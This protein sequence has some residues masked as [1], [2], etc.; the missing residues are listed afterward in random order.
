MKTRIILLTLA[1]SVCCV[2]A[3]NVT[4][5]WKAQFDTQ[6]GLQK[7]T[8]TLQQDGT[9]VS[10]NASAE[11]NGAKRESELKEGKIEGD[12]VSF[13]EPLNIQGNDLRITYTGKV[14]DNEIKFTRQVGDFATTEAVAKR[15]SATAP[16]QPAPAAKTVRIKAGKSEPVKDAE[17]NVWLADQG[18]EGGQT[19]ERPDIQI[20]NTKSP[21]LY[22]A[23]RY[24][25]DSFSWPVP[26]GKYV[27]KLH[28]AET[29]DGITG[30]GE[31]V[32]SFN[33][34]G[35]EFK[36]FDVWVKAGGA[37]KAYVERVPVE[38][39]NG[40]IK[41]TFTPKVENPQICALEIIPQT[42]AETGAAAP[43]P[44]AKTIRIKAG[45][46][47]PV[48]DAEGNVW[49]AD[50]G[51]EG[52][53]TI[54]RPDIQVANTK[55]P[56]LYRAEHY[57]MDSFSWPVPNGKYLV[58]LHF[59]ETFEGITGPGERVFSF[60][61]QGKEFKDFDVWVKAGGFLKAYIETVPVEV[62]EG[63]IKVTFTPKVENPQICAIEI[64]PQ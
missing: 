19:I 60:N 51:F 42:G 44:A 5:V 26:N 14:A 62:T 31:R 54:E 59:A 12:T 15:E 16:A 64:I 52:G 41:V 55:N 33:V 10:G 61:V 24:S 25:M 3:A 58:K 63:K 38:V 40:K 50:Q 36:D 29:F 7:Y 37:L 27:V 23:E 13:V 21:D 28:F 49:L 46:S 53:Q 47:E 4:G 57:S 1:L 6:R 11:V 9:K 56:G 22:R 30:L 8:F 35:R 2:W 20:A 18:F 48:K 32:F 34:Q 39:T 43:A 17:G 45:K